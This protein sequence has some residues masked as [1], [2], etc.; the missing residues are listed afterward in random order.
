LAAAEFY[1]LMPSDNSATV[2]AG[3]AVSFPESGPSSGSITSSSGTQFSLGS[4]G[5]YRVTFVVSVTEAG[6]L[7]LSL[8][9]SMLA[10]TVVGRA[11]GTSEIVGDALVQTTAPN[12]VLA[13]INPPGE[14]T[15]LTITPLAGGVNS[16]SASLV[17]QEI[18]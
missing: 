6:Q 17:I 2:G 16:V 8:N 15:A 12:A 5:T 4:A 1:A 11:T 10:Y 14:S 7:A 13:V 9:G 18:G 3:V